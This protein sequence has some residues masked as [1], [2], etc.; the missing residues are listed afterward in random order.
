MLLA[1]KR[2]TSAVEA[3]KMI[4]AVGVLASLIG[5][6]VLPLAYKTGQTTATEDVTLFLHASGWNGVLTGFLSALVFAG[7]YILTRRRVSY[8]GSLRDLLQGRAKD[9]DYADNRG[10]YLGVG[11]ITV[12]VI[13][14]SVAVRLVFG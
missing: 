5:W 11:W 8:F 9:L 3:L 4:S 6:V 2:G 13:V 10:F 12:F 7:C 14:V 1:P